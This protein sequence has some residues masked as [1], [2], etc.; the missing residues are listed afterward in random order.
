MMM[1][2]I[3]VSFYSHRPPLLWGPPGVGKTRFAQWLA[4]RLGVRSF[5]VCLSHKADNEV[6]GQPV[7]SKKTVELNGKEC[8]VVEQAPPQYAIEAMKASGAGFKGSIIVYDELTCIPPSTAGPALAIFG[9]HRIADR[10]L[11]PDT[12]A[13]LAC[14]NPAEQAAGGWNLAPPTSRRFDHL[15]FQLNPLD[16]AEHFPGY[17]DE[18]PAMG[19]FGVVVPEDE[20]SR[21]RALIAAYI[22]TFPEQLFQWPKDAAKRGGCWTDSNVVHVGGWANPATWDAV[23]RHLTNSRFLELSDTATQEMLIGAIGTEATMQ[24]QTWRDKMDM[25]TPRELLDKP[26]LVS[27]IPSNRADQLYYAMN[28]CVE[29]FKQSLARHNEKISDPKARERVISDWKACWEVSGRIVLGE[30]AK[31]GYRESVRQVT[32]GRKSMKG[33]M[34]IG[35]IGVKAIVR[36]EKEGKLRGA[37]V[38]EAPEI[39][40]FPDILRG[41]GLDWSLKKQ[42]DN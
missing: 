6:H 23:S 32:A 33:P 30:S 15:K 41:A 14:A 12:V 25:P 19:R 27:K 10:D 26:E 22:R 36:V 5:F 35:A 2:Q 3:L 39:D 20:W 34:D 13:T 4:R 7:I 18:P 28:G 31:N 21:D 24:F 29:L 1:K 37:P 9:E 11:D 8:T 42:R 40:L 16:W 38:T 17:W